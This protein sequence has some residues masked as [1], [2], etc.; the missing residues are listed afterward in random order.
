MTTMEYAYRLLPLLIIILAYKWPRITL[1]LVCMLLKWWVAAI[2]VLIVSIIAMVKIN[3]KKMT[4]EEYQEYI[5][6]K[7]KDDDDS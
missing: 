2:G 4:R 6:Q 7:E 1:I 3:I 5:S